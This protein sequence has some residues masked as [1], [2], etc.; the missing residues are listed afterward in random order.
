MNIRLSFYVMACLV[1]LVS[2][3][4]GYWQLAD[5]RDK[6]KAV[7]WI[8]AANRLADV[9][10]QTSAA[11][12]ME[13]GITAA[14]LA[15]PAAAQ[16]S[17]LDEMHRV[18]A[19]VDA[20][21]ARLDATAASLARRDATHPVFAK[22]HE[23]PLDPPRMASLRAQV[24][25]RLSGEDNGLDADRWIAL[26]TQRIG[27]LQ[28]LA[29]ISMQPLRGNRYTLASALVIKDVLFT[30]SEYAGRE[31]AAIGVAIAGHAPLSAY[32]WRTLEDQRVVAD[33]ARQRAE[34]I[35]AHLPGTPQ[36]M[37]AR[38]RFEADYLGRYEALRA[39][40]MARSLAGEP[41]PV[42]A[43]EWYREATNGV[44]AILGLSSALSAQFDADIA[45]LRTHAVN[46][47]GMLILLFMAMAVLFGVA[48]QGVRRR[49]LHPLLTLER[50]A[51]TIAA[52]DLTQAL[53]AQRPDEL[54]RLGEAF[55]R[56][57]QTLLADRHQRERDTEALRKLDALIEQSASAMI[58]TDAHGVIEYAN[59]PFT[60]ITGYTREEAI[61]RKAGFWR[62]ERT[63]AALYREMWEAALS[64]K[65]WEGEMINRRKNG[66]LYWA[67]MLLSPVTDDT[68]QIT[69]FI[70][71]Q[72]DISERRRIEERLNF[73][74]AY[75][76]LTGLPNRS[77]LAQ[78]FAEIHAEAEHRG[79]MIGFITIGIG[80]FKRINDSLGRDVGDQL[81]KVI[82]QRL[83]DCV[84]A[85]DT[86]SRHGGTEFVV[87]TPELLLRDTLHEKVTRII[88]TLNLPVVIQGERLQPS[89][90]AGV[91]MMPQDGG[92]LD[93]LLRKATIAL[94]HAERHGLGVCL[95]TEALDQDAQERL[96]LE[97]A[98]RSALESCAL[99]LHYQPK[100]DLITGRIVGVE[101][102]ARWAHP[103]THEQVPPSRFIPIAEESGLIQHLGAWALRQACLQNK[104]WLDAGL[105]RIV[106]AVN[107]SA[108]QLSQPNLV[109]A[110]AEILRETGLPPSLL[111]LELTESALMEDPEQ[112]NDVLRR[113]KA[114]GLRLAIDDFG[115]G[116]SSLAYL[117][118]F[119]VDQLKIDRRFITQ[120]AT[121]AASEAISTSVIA[122][123]HQ[124][125]L[126]V[127]AEGVETEEQL[128]FLNRHGCDEIQ[129]YYYSAPMPAS[130]CAVLLASGKKLIAADATVA[131]TLLVVDDEPAVLAMMTLALD[132]QGY[133]VL[134]ARSAR[135]ALALLAS[136][137][138]QV[139]VTDQRMP[140][141][142]GAELL[143]RVGTRYPDM[144]RIVIS[145][146]AESELL[147]AA[148]SSGEI[149][150]FFTKPWDEA[151]LRHQILEAFRDQAARVASRR[152]AGAGQAVRPSDAAPMPV[153]EAEPKRR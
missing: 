13:R 21:H 42:D 19:A 7:E 35:L 107:L 81:L 90:N 148:V 31:R 117:S 77:L 130:A 112:A 82:A 99:E 50:A 3:A 68:G 115:T 49:V 57:R 48:V 146:H 97:G 54:G 135:E 136:N 124:M 140:D 142:D 137:E 71:I 65:V 79:T 64:G 108:N 18:R 51:A 30:L 39:Q 15:N 26:M 43:G 126:R 147:H 89:I 73:L 138:V 61:G 129:G 134:T 55:E 85:G 150:K 33:R 113:L 125:G 98:L 93:V 36:L 103:L 52:G 28:D 2:A 27:S 60:A 32:A 83:G 88:E 22:L 106:V 92:N 143:A 76:E 66:E 72:S 6:Q 101:A 127:I 133:R 131:R 84:A 34:A 41:Y 78:R 111:E 118:E 122:L 62:S 105:P 8:Q 23:L 69:H 86:V 29:A 37:Q 144:L 70:S 116:Y 47:Q 132:G 63:A 24:D 95:C 145:G 5:S 149:Y 151:R 45:Q 38:L 94:H 75:D 46:T 16:A 40:I 139:L 80:R 74:S 152:A 10:Q 102:L 141:M 96:A 20:R 87:M 128:E 59:T 110:V 114:L 17:M 121:D 53:P 4:A 12:A 44:D 67:S 109:E 56:M 58:V 11:L 14:I 153:S 91:S 123:A 119:P 120:I 100:V 104:A 1:A 9:A 25:A